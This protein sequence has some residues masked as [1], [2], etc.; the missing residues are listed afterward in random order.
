MLGMKVTPDGGRQPRSSRIR[1]H[2]HR[3][4]C[5]RAQPSLARITDAK[6]WLVA[7]ATTICLVFGIEKG[8]TKH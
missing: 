3:L 8:S 2:R 7:P 1:D 5:R 6:G 4:A